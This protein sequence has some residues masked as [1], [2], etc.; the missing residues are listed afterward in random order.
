MRTWVT[1]CI[2][3]PEQKIYEMYAERTREFLK[4]SDLQA[5][6]TTFPKLMNT[7]T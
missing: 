1:L 5:R 3:E 2:N 4:V 6:I 7:S